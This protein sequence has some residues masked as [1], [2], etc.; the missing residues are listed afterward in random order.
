MVGRAGLILCAD[1]VA[2]GFVAPRA[3]IL[4]VVRDG[5]IVEVRHHRAPIWT[6]TMR[7]AIPMRV[8]DW[9]R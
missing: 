8:T 5:G 6:A 7:A 2:R 3:L 4:L 9:N 1:Q